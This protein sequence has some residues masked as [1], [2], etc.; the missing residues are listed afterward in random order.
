VKNRGFTC[1]AAVMIS[2]IVLPRAALAQSKDT[3]KAVQNLTKRP[4]ELR[5][6][7]NS[8]AAVELR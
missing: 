6:Q 8:A 1:L 2:G 5:E 7:M 3:R 4:D